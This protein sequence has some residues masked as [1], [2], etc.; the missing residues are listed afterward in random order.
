M[1]PFRQVQI[2]T[3][4]TRRQVHVTARPDQC[5]DIGHMHPHALALDTDGII[6][7]LVA[8]V[9]DRPCLQ[10]GQIAARLLRQ[11]GHADLRRA[12]LYADPQRPGI[13]V[14]RPVA[15]AHEK[16]VCRIRGLWQIE[17]SQ[18]AAVRG[19]PQCHA[20]DLGQT[21]AVFVLEPRRFDSL[22][23]RCPF[24]FRALF[25]LTRGA[26]GMYGIGT[27]AADRLWPTFE[28]QAI[29]QDLPGAPGRGRRKLAEQDLRQV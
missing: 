3:A 9:V 20:L 29:L 7:V 28:V 10:V 15:A 5:G 22:Q 19:H 14:R 26:L 21:L 17:A 11:V 1:N 8:D 6:G 23:E 13:M 25:L 4:L 18:D 24:L 16:T 12:E 2:R 27:A